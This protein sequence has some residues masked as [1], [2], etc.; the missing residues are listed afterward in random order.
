MTRWHYDKIA[1]YDTIH[2]F[3]EMLMTMQWWDIINWKLQQ[4]VFPQQQVWQA[5]EAIRAFLEAPL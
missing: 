2:W 3:K 1:L 5:L 4:V